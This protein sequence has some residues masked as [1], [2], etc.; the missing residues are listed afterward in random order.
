MGGKRRVLGTKAL[1]KLFSFK[2]WEGG[3][4]KKG[5]VGIGGGPYCGKVFPF[6]K[7]KWFWG[8]KFKEGPN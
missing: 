6:L 1:K 7:K 3:D 4:P 5:R 2:I 8:G